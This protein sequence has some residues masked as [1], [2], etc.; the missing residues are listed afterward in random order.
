MYKRTMTAITLTMSAALVALPAQAETEVLLIGAA[1]S[2]D[3]MVELRASLKKDFGVDGIQVATAGNSHDIAERVRTFLGADGKPDEFR[4]VWVT[5]NAGGDICPGFDEV[6]V[7][8]QARSLV[9]AP[10]CLKLVIQAPTTYERFGAEN[11][12]DR[13]GVDPRAPAVAFVSSADSKP[14]EILTKPMGTLAQTLACSHIGHIALDFSPSVVAWGVSA[15][16]CQISPLVQRSAEVAPAAMP[17]ATMPERAPEKSLADQLAAV[18]ANQFN[19]VA[20]VNGRVVSAY[21]S[22]VAGKPNKGIDIEVPA[23]TVATAAESGEV[24]FV[25]ELPGYGQ[26]VAIK[27]DN[28]WATIYART[29]RPRVTQGQKVTKGQDLTDVDSDAKRLHFEVRRK[30]KP[31]DPETLMAVHG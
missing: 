17:T 18:P 16:G 6:P 15:N 31:I 14:S 19:L 24:V 21:G 11:Q 30:G 12:D 27:H 22:Q 1:H 2:K 3:T 20:P 10:S 7:R 5:G 29:A 23:G 25:G 28:D 9:V 26:V 4:V 8:P 13:G